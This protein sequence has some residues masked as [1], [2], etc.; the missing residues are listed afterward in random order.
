MIGN[1]YNAFYSKNVKSAFD[2]VSD[3]Y[4]EIVP[5][6]RCFERLHFVISGSTDVFKCEVNGDEVF[7]GNTEPFV[8]SLDDI[9]IRSFKIYKCDALVNYRFIAGINKNNLE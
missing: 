5:D 7:V 2:G 3:D 1:S 8:I 4:I 6:G 9:T